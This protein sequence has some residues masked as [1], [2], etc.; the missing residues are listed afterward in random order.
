MN[1]SPQNTLKMN[2]KYRP[3]L[4]PTGVV[5][6]ETLFF[7]NLLT[8]FDI[9]LVNWISGLQVLGGAYIRKIGLELLTTDRLHDLYFLIREVIQLIDQLVNLAV[10][11]FDLTFGKRVS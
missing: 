1:T 6:E 11:G 10:G 4:S 8:R 7:S 3:R 9:I 2:T 5:K